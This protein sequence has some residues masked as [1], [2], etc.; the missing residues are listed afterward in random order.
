MNAKVM[1]DGLGSMGLEAQMFSIPSVTADTSTQITFP[2]LPK[3]LIITTSSSYTPTSSYSVSCVPP[4]ETNG[5]IRAYAT[6]SIVIILTRSG[7]TIG[8]QLS[9]AD[10][11]KMDIIAFF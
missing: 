5:T 11:H 1:K 9:V 7:N 10:K 4:L 8:F 3:F 2:S 6:Y